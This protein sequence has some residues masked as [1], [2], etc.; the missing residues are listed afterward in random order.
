M[1][2]ITH[3]KYESF[4]ARLQVRSVFLNISKTFD[5]VRH[6]GMI[7][8]VTQ[9]GILGNLVNFLQDLLKENKQLVA[10]TGQVST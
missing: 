4:D 6:D 3:K 1:L 5:K 7:L 2:S 8:K 10:L 9:N